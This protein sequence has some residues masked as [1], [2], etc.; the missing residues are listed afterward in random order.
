[1]SDLRTLVYIEIPPWKTTHTSVP[2]FDFLLI[3]E[4][5]SGNVPLT[6]FA[7]SSLQSPASNEQYKVIVGLCYSEPLLDTDRLPQWAM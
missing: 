7:L 4:G 5:L 1:M 2:Y 3:T 6:T